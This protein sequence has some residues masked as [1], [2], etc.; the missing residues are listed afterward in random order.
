M[1]VRGRNKETNGFNKIDLL[2][3]ITSMQTL[4]SCSQHWIRACLSNAC[5]KQN[6]PIAD[7]SLMVGIHVLL[8]VLVQHLSVCFFSITNIGFLNVMAKCHPVNESAY[9]SDTGPW[10]TIKSLHVAWMWDRNYFHLISSNDFLIW[11]KTY[12][13]GNVRLFRYLTEQV[14]HRHSVSSNDSGRL[15]IITR[16]WRHKLSHD[17]NYC[18]NI[19]RYR[20]EPW[21]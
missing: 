10:I 21:A 14:Q 19:T 2:A 20:R 15:R 18:C 7:I 17:G 11:W 6:I 1:T 9:N 5:C 12:T 3:H 13:E 4:K 8:T 16:V